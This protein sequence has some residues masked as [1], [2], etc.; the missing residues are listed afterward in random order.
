MAYSKSVKTVQAGSVAA[1]DAMISAD[2]VRKKIDTVLDKGASAFVATLV[3][4]VKQNAKLAACDPKTILASAMTAATMKLPINPNL[5]F[6][7]IVPY[8]TEASFQIG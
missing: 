4:M 8:K 3:S 7:Y 6:A 5:G 2:I 1:F